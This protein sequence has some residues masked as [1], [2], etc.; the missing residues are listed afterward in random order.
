L[1][2]PG[3]VFLCLLVAA[4]PVFGFDGSHTHTPPI[5]RA[6][7]GQVRRD[8]FSGVP[9]PPPPSPLEKRDPFSGVPLNQD[10]Q[11]ERNDLRRSHQS[12]RHKDRGW[13]EKHR[14]EEFERHG[15]EPERGDFRERAE[16]RDERDR[17]REEPRH[18]R[19]RPPEGSRFP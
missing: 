14:A 11:Y 10:Q 19:D 15:G 12:D 2:H 18:G 17:A 1:R 9:L 6:P 5:V 4:P 7:S 8:P 3:E 16:S 13:K